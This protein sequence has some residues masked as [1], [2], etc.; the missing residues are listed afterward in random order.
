MSKK[1][2]FIKNGIEEEVWSN[3]LVEMTKYDK[4]AVQEMGSKIEN[5]QKLKQNILSNPQD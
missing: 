4:I 2:S 3:E 1:E 5:M